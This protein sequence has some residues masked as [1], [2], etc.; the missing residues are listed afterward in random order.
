MVEGPTMSC[1]K[2]SACHMLMHLVRKASCADRGPR[3]MLLHTQWTF[4][5]GVEHTPA[6]ASYESRS[7]LTGEGVSL[8]ADLITVPPTNM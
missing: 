8:V 3:R 7:V 4:F 5:H 2:T 1:Y 6:I